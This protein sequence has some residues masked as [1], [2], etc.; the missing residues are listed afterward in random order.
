MPKIARI[1]GICGKEKSKHD[2]LPAE[3]I[4]PS[5]LDLIKQKYPK[6]N[7]ESFIC[8]DDLNLYRNL[9]VSEVIHKEKGELSVLEQDALRSLEE[10]EF[11]AKNI[12]KE[13][14]GEMTFGER[15]ADKITDF[16]GSWTFIILFLFWLF[17]WI[18]VNAVQFLWK[19]FDPFPFILLNLVLSCIAALQA[20]VILMSQNRQ[21]K[22]DRL[23]SEHDFKVD[24]KAEL[25]IR[26]IQAKIDQLM[27][28][29]WQRLLEIQHIQLELLQE[30]VKK[31]THVKSKTKKR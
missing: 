22:K 6:F 15:A 1:C 25:E 24:M 29:Q 14:E 28:H 26:H 5:L 18:G 2:I 31:N 9:Y 30:H 19:P 13:F 11:I 16:A 10:H 4:R 12:V 27:S 21:T 17:A 23:Q 8:T 3:F 7:D 20:P